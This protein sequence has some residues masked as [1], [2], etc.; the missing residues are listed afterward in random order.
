MMIRKL[1]NIYS[2]DTIGK[3]KPDGIESL[4]KKGIIKNISFSR[5]QDGKFILSSPDPWKILNILDD[6]YVKSLL[7]DIPYEASEKKEI[8]QN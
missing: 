5:D 3:I 6:D 1:N 8:K 4:I 7:T 2:R